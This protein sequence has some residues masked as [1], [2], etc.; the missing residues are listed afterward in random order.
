MISPKMLAKQTSRT[1]PISL[2]NSLR[3]SALL[4]RLGLI[5]MSELLSIE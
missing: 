4:A 5:D 1:I 3:P 2:Y